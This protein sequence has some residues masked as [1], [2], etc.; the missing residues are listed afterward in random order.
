MPLS[1]EQY[2]MVK[3]EMSAMIE[4][5]MDMALEVDA[6]NTGTGEMK[7]IPLEVFDA[8]FSKHRLVLS[9]G[10]EETFWSVVQSALLEGVT[11]GND[12]LNLRYF[13]WHVAEALDA[14]AVAVASH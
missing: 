10:A 11:V 6:R 13:T 12:G 7:T 4:V 5:A 14:C 8:V 9:P 1:T 2:A 3:N